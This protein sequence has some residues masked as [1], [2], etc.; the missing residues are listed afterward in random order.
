M[1][2]KFFLQAKGQNEDIV[3]SVGRL[4]SF[5]NFGKFYMSY[6]VRSVSFNSVPLRSFILDAVLTLKDR[7]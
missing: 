7:N 4:H 6:D 5:I 3:R 1:M 2:K